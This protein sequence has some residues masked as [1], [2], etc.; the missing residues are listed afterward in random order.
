[1]NNSSRGINMLNQLIEANEFL[2]FN[3]KKYIQHPA[4]LIFMWYSDDIDETEV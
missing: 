1:M 2:T 4:Y 3:F